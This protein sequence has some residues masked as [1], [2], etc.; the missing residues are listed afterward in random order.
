MLDRLEIPR[1]STCFDFS[2]Q[3]NN[4]ANHFILHDFAGRAY[5]VYH[6]IPGMGAGPLAGDPIGGI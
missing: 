5:L 4:K 1:H 2:L 3:T 6:P